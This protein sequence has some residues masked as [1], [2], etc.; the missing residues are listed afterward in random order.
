MS[1]NGKN[2]NKF[3][4]ML[5]R[6]GIIRKVEQ[7]DFDSGPASPVHSPVGKPPYDDDLRALMNLSNEDVPAPVRQTAQPVPGIIAG[8]YPNSKDVSEQ[9]TPAE[10]S[11]F[12]WLN[13][14]I[15][16]KAKEP[17]RSP[18][19][20]LVVEELISEATSEQL[21]NATVKP[22]TA[23]VP[24]PPVREES[25]VMSSE[26]VS[27]DVP[28]T[29]IESPS[30]WVDDDDES[31]DTTYTGEQPSA[32]NLTDRYLTVGELYDALT[33]KS[34]KTDTIYLIEDY[35][36]TLPDSLP[37]ESRRKI[38]KQIVASSGFDYD[39]LMGDGILRVKLLKEY[40][41]K[42]ARY[43]EDYV[44][45]HQKEIFKLENQIVEI[46]NLIEKRRDLHKKQFL[47]IEA[48]AG[49]LREILAFING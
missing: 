32:D 20:A 15:E 5:E 43:T 17:Q 7:D 19:V 12:D 35:L 22:S 11:A 18:D 30:A 27:A 6:R 9:F 3:M 1:G 40:A 49:R 29:E 8:V 33:L 13:E 34:K 2:E 16:N 44:A 46:H 4:A 31:T 14:S 24:E 45:A 39:I 23:P 10:A 26:R 37:D 38:I 42:F 41:E 47:S 21:E 48:E 36:K 25:P 28:N